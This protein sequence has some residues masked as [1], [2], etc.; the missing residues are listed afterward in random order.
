VAYPLAVA[1]LSALFSAA[2]LWQYALRRKPHQLIWM[3][4]LLMSSAASMAY[5]LALPPTANEGAFRAYY[6]LGAVL[7]PAWLGLGSIYL[8]A[9]PQLRQWSLSALM[10]ASALG[11]GAVMAAPISGQQLARLNGGPGVGVLL[12]G[13]WLPLTIVLN[14]CG[15]AAVVGVAIYSAARVARRHA[16]GRLLGA[17]LAIA[18]GDL[19]IGAAGSMAR[20]GFPDLFWI[21]MFTGWVVIFAGFLLASYQPSAGDQSVSATEAGDRTEAPGLPVRARSR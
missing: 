14:T 8:V 9:P 20:T 16:P 1:G 19:I 21:T 6:A 17:N 13:P 7:M 4:A 11:V 10:V 18:A 2:L 12:A 5:V 15:V 3:T